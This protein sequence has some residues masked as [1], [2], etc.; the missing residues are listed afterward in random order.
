MGT[1]V[2]ICMVISAFV[3]LVGGLMMIVAAFRQSILWGVAYLLIPFA[4]LVFLCKYWNEAKKGFFINLAGACAFVG[5]CFSFPQ[6]RPE[7]LSLLMG[8]WDPTAA[9]PAKKENDYARAIEEKRQHIGL[10][11]AELAKVTA[12][13]DVRFKELSIQ[14]DSLNAK[15][16]AAVLQFNVEAT[17]YLKQVEQVKELTQKVTVA[18]MEVDDLLARQVE[19]ETT[20]VVIY[21]TS[22]C[23]VCKTAKRYMDSKGIKYREVDVE[24]SKEGAAEYRQQGGDGSVPLIVIGDKKVKGFDPHAF[25]SML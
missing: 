13:A 14:R 19:A 3:M 15:D 23:S 20:Q 24:K 18:N 1:I 8:R 10:L 12:A 5:C 6:A 21:S 4:A 22:W 7:I 11:Q 16:T 2:V 25:D 17:A 9:A